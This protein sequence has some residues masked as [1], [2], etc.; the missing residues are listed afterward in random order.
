MFKKI[1]TK[2][3]IIISSICAVLLGCVGVV[4]AYNLSNPEKRAI[5]DSLKKDFD[6]NKNNLE[7]MGEAKNSKEAEEKTRQSQDLK[8]QGL[9]IAAVG[10]EVKTQEEFT[11]ELRSALI[12]TK[13]G[14]E[15]T[16]MASD[17]KTNEKVKSFIEKSEKKVA[18]IEKE[19]AENKKT[20]EQLLKELLDR[21]DVDN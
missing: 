6:N 1:I 7:A 21:T 14:L 5:Y 20:P 3:A 10:N 12:N 19:F 18:R 15:D 11:E 13:R 17:A 8:K 2:K 9:E 16:K 4:G